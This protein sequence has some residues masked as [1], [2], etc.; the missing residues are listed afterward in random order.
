M[1]LEVVLAAFS[2]LI[3]GRP[4]MLLSPECRTLRN[5][6]N[7]GYHFRKLR[8]GVTGLDY[9]E[10]PAKT[11]PSHVAEALQYVLLGG[12]DASL[13]MNKVKRRARPPRE[14]ADGVDYD[15]FAPTYG[16]ARKSRLEFSKDF[17]EADFVQYS[18]S[19]TEVSK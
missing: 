12:G 9:D 11:F 10:R 14:R 3:D 2:R 4:G 5:A 18:T 17:Y 1:R 13:V 19:Q 8:S 6:C 16:I 15:V 7:G